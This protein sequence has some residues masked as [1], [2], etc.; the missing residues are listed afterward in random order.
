MQDKKFQQQVARF[1]IGNLIRGMAYPSFA[2]AGLEFEVAHELARRS[3][4]KPRGFLVPFEV[5][6][7]DLVV[8]TATAGGHTVATN[9][10]TNK[11]VDML[12]PTSIIANLGA[13]Y[14]NDLVGGVAVPRQT[15]GATAYWVA[16]NGAPT[17]SQAAF[18]QVPMTP[19]TLGAFTDVSRKMLLQSSLEIKGFV[20]ADLLASLGQELDRV[21]LAG[22]GSGNE[23][24][25]IL[26]N[27]AISTVSLG[28][29]G[30]ALTWANVVDLESTVAQANGDGLNM[31]YVT[32]KQVRGKMSQTQKVAATGAP[33]I[34]E[35]S[36]RPQLPGEGVVNGLRAIAS[37][38]I[39]SNLTKG[40]G[41]NLSAMICGN[42]SDL[43]VGQWGA[44]I[45]IILDPYVNST[46][47]AIR[48][49]AMTDVDF[50]IRHPESFIKI[51]DIV[52]T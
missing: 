34:W 32:T 11:Y 40:S 51:K 33:F 36:P 47:G 5:M 18:D 46:N 10:L 44:G 52:T 20:I 12:R 1:D 37:T 23:P 26:N 8:G 3:P 2:G 24:T 50:A 21:V 30:A 15:S 48:I 45:E 25:G 38:L 17:E 27:S 28:T 29:N 22:S 42:W 41:T 49:I 13:T 14:L 9:L 43:L 39:P 4:T 7:R 31:G 35:N 16:E 19:K 6:K